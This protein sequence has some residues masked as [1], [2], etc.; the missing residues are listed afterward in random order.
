M[1][2]TLTQLGQEK[3]R[4]IKNALALKGM[5]REAFW[6]TWMKDLRISSKRGWPQI[7][8]HPARLQDY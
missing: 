7:S 4:G 6:A 1:Q 8:T 2:A 5:K 3:E